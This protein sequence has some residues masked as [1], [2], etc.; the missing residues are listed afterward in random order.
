MSQNENL[1]FF[2]SRDIR[3]WTQIWKNLVRFFHGLG[4]QKFCATLPHHEP[5]QDSGL[6]DSPSPRPS[7]ARRGRII[8]RLLETLQ[9]VIGFTG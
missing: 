2:M 5:E 3:R 1:Y 6:E 8:V 9:E 4:I 7:P